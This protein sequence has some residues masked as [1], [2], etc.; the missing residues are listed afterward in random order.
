MELDEN[1]PRLKEE[2]VETWEMVKT[3]MQKQR[4][5]LVMEKNLGKMINRAIR[6]IKNDN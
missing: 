6:T 4:K 3:S 1:S 2:I 5:K